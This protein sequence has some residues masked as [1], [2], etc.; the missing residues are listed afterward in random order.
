MKERRVKWS[1]YITP[2]NQKGTR[3]MLKGV[4]LLVNKQAIWKGRTSSNG[5]FEF[6][7]TSKKTLVFSVR[8]EE[9]IGQ[10]HRG[11]VELITGINRFN[12]PIQ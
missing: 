7:V 5:A 12:A 8:F 2:A 4:A 3:E 1:N 11:N 9:K 6:P 10:L